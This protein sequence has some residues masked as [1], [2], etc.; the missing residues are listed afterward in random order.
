MLDMSV[1]RE[2]FPIRPIWFGYLLLLPDI[3]S[4]AAMA[5]ERNYRLK[6]DEL[7]STFRD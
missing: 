6:R 1:V 7:L 5:D 3:T 4:Q 2:S